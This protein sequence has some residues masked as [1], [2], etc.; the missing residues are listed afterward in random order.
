MDIF[1]V[2]MLMEIAPDDAVWAPPELVSARSA[3]NH[4]DDGPELWGQAYRGAHP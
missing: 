3:L 1:G 4:R 2:P